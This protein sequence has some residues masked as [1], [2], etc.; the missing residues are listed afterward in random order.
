MLNI[1]K[2]KFRYLLAATPSQCQT[3]CQRFSVCFHQLWPFFGCVHGV[4]S[5]AALKQRSSYSA[6]I[7]LVQWQAAAALLT[8]S[9]WVAGYNS[10]CTTVDTGPHKPHSTL[11][12]EMEE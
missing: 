5:R 2:P 3:Q 11:G 6:I 4:C 8:L 10:R 7:H 1:L 12:E 9:L